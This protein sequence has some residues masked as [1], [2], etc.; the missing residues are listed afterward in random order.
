MSKKKL[1][2]AYKRLDNEEYTNVIKDTLVP[3]FD[4]YDGE[5]ITM[6]KSTTKFEIEKH[7]HDNSFMGYNI[8]ADGELIETKST[9]KKAKKFIEKLRS[10]FE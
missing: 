5:F 4:D 10:D 9:K 2:H 8:Y 1:K 3:Y 6:I 7:Y